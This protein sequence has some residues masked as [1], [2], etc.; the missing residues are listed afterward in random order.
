MDREALGSGEGHL[1]IPGMGIEEPFG[2]TLK[3]CP[4]TIPP[5]G[6]GGWPGFFALRPAPGM[7]PQK[8]ERYRQAAIPLFGVRVGKS[9]DSYTFPLL[10]GTGIERLDLPVVFFGPFFPPLLGVGLG[11]SLECLPVLGI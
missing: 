3:Q 8:G 10:L 11:P 1:G 5:G 9:S 6:S 4:F 2:R 7:A